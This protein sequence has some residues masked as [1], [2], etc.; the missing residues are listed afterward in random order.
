MQRFSG[1]KVG[2]DAVL[3][4]EKKAVIRAIHNNDADA[5]ATQRKLKALIE[6]AA[7]GGEGKAVLIIGPSGSGKSHALA[8]F[9]A[10]SEFEPIVTDEATM[11]PLVY[12]VA[13]SPCTLLALGHVIYTAM[14]GKELNANQRL[15]AVWRMVKAQLRGRRVSILVIDEMHHV[16]A[17]KGD[18][19]RD[20]ISETLKS[21]LVDD[22]WPMQLV[23]AGMPHAH[24]FVR[25]NPQLNRRTKVYSFEPL[26]GD[27]DGTKK[28]RKY[29]DNLEAKLPEGMSFDFDHTD[30]VQRFH[31][32]TDGYLGHVA[33][34]VKDAA[35]L[36]VELGKSA[37]TQNELAAEYADIYECAS[38]ENP[39]LVESIAKLKPPS[40]DVDLS[41]RTRM[42]GTAAA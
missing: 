6:N 7:S 12:V 36:A 15:H 40:V 29:L 27:A 20:V 26:R 32:A 18:A 34:L 21:M 23:L 22:K 14:T 16:L 25:Q 31:M 37:V 5:L 17:K 35:C 30:I 33:M 39:F 3:R 9:R 28:I 24:D 11:Q 2:P 38:A 42:K 41:E 4:R 8:Q 19:D 1:G 10:L 13:P